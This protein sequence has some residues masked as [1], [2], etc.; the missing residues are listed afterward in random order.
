MHGP[1]AIASTRYQLAAINSLCEKA[2]LV[3]AGLP[4][5][6]LSGMKDSKHPVATT[7]DDEPDAP[8]GGAKG[9]PS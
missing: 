4:I 1:R 8:H 9:Q 3:L 5:Q 7:D 2:D 6:H